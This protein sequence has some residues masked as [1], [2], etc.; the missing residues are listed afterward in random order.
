MS[1][2]FNHFLNDKC[3]IYRLVK[4]EVAGNTPQISHEKIEGTFYCRHEKKMVSF[5]KSIVGDVPSSRD[6]LFLSPNIEIKENYRVKLNG[7]EYTVHEVIPMKR[8]KTVHHLEVELK[9]R[10]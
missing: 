1:R 4:K 10:S 3:E 7:S 2:L 9:A 8:F 5:T 6:I